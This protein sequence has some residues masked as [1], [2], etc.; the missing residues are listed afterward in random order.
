MAKLVRV[1]VQDEPGKLDR[2]TVMLIQARVPDLRDRARVVAHQ[3]DPLQRGVEAPQGSS[4]QP[5]ADAHASQAGERGL[6]QAVL[7]DVF[8]ELVVGDLG[9]GRGT[10][11]LAQLLADSQASSHRHE[12]CLLGPVA[13]Q[14][15]SPQGPLELAH[16]AG[17]DRFEK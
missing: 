7:L 15:T 8:G 13:F 9:G 11:P 12:G 5:V 3:P 4:D 10:E 1:R 14:D 6:Y 17:D 2:R 16:E